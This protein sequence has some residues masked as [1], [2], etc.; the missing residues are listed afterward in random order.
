[1][2]AR[3]TRDTTMTASTTAALRYALRLTNTAASTGYFACVLETAMDFQTAMA[4]LRVHPMD[5]FMHQHLLG[6]ISTWAPQQLVQALDATEPNDHVAHA[7]V[8]EASL[9]DPRLADL[10]NRFSREDA[11]RLAEYSPLLHI[12]ADLLP[13]SGRHA[14]WIR[15]FRQNILDLDPV[16]APTGDDLDLPP[17]APPARDIGAVF[18]ERGQVPA[19]GGSVDAEAA[20]AVHDAALGRLQ[21]LDILDGPEMRHAASLSPIALLRQW[22]FSHTIRQGRL[23]YRFIGPQTSYGRGLVLETARAACVMEVVERWSAYASI[24]GRRIIGRADEGEIDHA[25][26][27]ALAAEDTAV[28]DP[29]RIALEVPYTDQTLVWVTGSARSAQGRFPIRVPLQCVYLFANYDEPAL[30]SALGS[31]G[32]ATGTTPEQ[33]QLSGL[34]EVVERDADMT[35]VFRWEDCFFLA[36]D[37]PSLGHLLADY[38]NQGIHLFFQ[39][40]SHD[41]GIP[42]YRCF[43][44]AQDGTVARGTA[45]H[46]D[47]RRAIISAMTETPHPYPTE[48]PTQMP[49]QH[50][51]TRLAASLPSF[52][53]GEAATDLDLVETVLVANGWEPVAVNITT[54]ALGYPVY[55]MIVPGMEIMSDFDAFSRVSPRLMAHYSATR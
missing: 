47:G 55:R 51:P 52:A 22:S 17:P 49:P 40:I 44:I 6:F 25:P 10:R 37:D 5:A 8:L 34:L 12:R 43:V 46:L 4:Y 28:L 54:E 20:M 9:M 18:D 26:F 50:L 2:I 15:A 27:S 38:R 35:H 1:M 32:L 16:D 39:D 14:R 29:N 31:T 23:N 42:C 3:P 11:L 21:A 30:F 7:L 24:D 33:A 19:T 13:D 45:G 41:T 36:D 48:M 53:T